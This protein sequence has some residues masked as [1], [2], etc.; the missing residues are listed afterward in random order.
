M[1]NQIKLYKEWKLMDMRTQ[2]TRTS[3]DILDEFQ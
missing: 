2:N 1:F 3:V